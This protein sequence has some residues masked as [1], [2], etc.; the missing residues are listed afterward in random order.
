[1]LMGAILTR[2]AVAVLAI[3]SGA[4]TLEPKVNGRSV[5]EVFSDPAAVKLIKLACTKRHDEVSNFSGI[6][7]VVNSIGSDGSTPLFW[8]ISCNSEI[9]VSLFLK[10]G[11][12]P[13]AFGGQKIDNTNP[14]IIAASYDNP[15]MLESILKYGGNPNSLSNNG[16]DTA[17]SVAF[18][19]GDT[20]NRWEN[21]YLLLKYGSDINYKSP[22]GRTIATKAVSLGWIS[23]AIEL[24]DKGYNKELFMLAINVYGRNIDISDIEYKNKRILIQKLADLKI[25]VAKARDI[26]IENNKKARID[27][28]AL[29]HFLKE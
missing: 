27:G 21:Y 6:E 15:N 23:K 9:S 14:V 25:N 3:S 8:A 4:C 12:N 20:K 24:I 16:E 7:K 29:D 10:K 2:I 5:S 22:S 1:M 19:L 28:L 11:A 18:S 26:V 17:L 13:N